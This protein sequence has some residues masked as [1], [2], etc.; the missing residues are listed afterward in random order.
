MNRGRG[1]VAR[2][3]EYKSTCTCVFIWEWDRVQS[4]HQGPWLK[5]SEGRDLGDLPRSEIARLQN[6]LTQPTPSLP[7]PSKSEP[8][9]PRAETSSPEV[10]RP[11]EPGSGLYLLTGSG[12]RLLTPQFPP[13]S[14]HGPAS[15]HGRRHVGRTTTLSVAAGADTDRRGRSR[16]KRSGAEAE[17]PA[18][19]GAEAPAPAPAASGSAPPV[20]GHRLLTPS[21]ALRL[22]SALRL[23]RHQNQIPGAQITPVAAEE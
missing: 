11:A 12:L 15:H 23:W 22:S 18:A 3:L 19:R 7:A 2:E 8:P 5:E 21:P 4:Y 14:E 13:L 6:H 1:A 10:S 20:P 17:L 9:D 16:G